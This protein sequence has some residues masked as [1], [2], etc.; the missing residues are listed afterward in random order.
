MELWKKFP[1]VDFGEA[2]EQLRE[3]IYRHV[4]ANPDE[5]DLDDV[6]NRISPPESALKVTPEKWSTNSSDKIQD[7]MLKRLLLMAKPQLNVQSALRKFVEIFHYRKRHQI[8]S[9]SAENTLPEEFYRLGIFLFDD[10]TV[11]RTGKR[12]MILRLRYLHQIAP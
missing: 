10:L 6:S 4:G 3:L 12:L 8:S 7:W 9:L 11:D 5:F 1:D 2:I